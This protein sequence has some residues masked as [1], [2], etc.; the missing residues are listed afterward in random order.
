MVN[1]FIFQCVRY[2]E[3]WI[4]FVLYTKIRPTFIELHFNNFLPVGTT[5]VGPGGGGIGPGIGPGGVGPGG[6]CATPC[7]FACIT[8]GGGPTC[9]C[10]QG[11]TQVGQG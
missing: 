3:T 9:G 4:H 5:G 2:Y 7:V 1:T 6:G 8:L 11:Y 10:P